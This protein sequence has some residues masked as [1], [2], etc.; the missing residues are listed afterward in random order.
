LFQNCFKTVFEKSAFFSTC[1]EL[2]GLLPVRQ[3]FKHFITNCKLFF[4]QVR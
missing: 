2:K 3:K 4:S 1:I